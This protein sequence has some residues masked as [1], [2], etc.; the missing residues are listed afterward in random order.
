MSI[1]FRVDIIKEY[2]LKYIAYQEQSE[3]DLWLYPEETITLKKGNCEE[4]AFLLASSMLSSGIS[5]YVVRVA[6]GRIIL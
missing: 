4:R 2:F 5:K 1:D 3:D 6:F